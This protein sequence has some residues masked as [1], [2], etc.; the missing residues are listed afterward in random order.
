VNDDLTPP[1]VP[2]MDEETRARVRARLAEATTTPDTQ[3]GWR[4]WVLPIAA[5]AAVLVVALGVG[6]VAWWPGDDAAAPAGETTAP[7][8]PTAATAEPTSPSTA[9]STQEASSEPSPTGEESRTAPAYPNPTG[10]SPCGKAVDQQLQGAIEQVATW[11]LP[12]GVAGIWAAGGQAVLCED[13]GGIATA[14]RAQST[15]AAPVDAEQLIWSTS[16]YPVEGGLQTA[17]VA[18][19]RLPEG[20]TGIEYAWPD[21]HV[22]RA[23]IVDEG[24]RRWWL[25]SYVPTDGALVERGTN[26]LQLDDVHVTVSLSGTQRTFDLPFAASMCAQVNHGC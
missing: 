26:F 15:E 11:Q 5:A 7:T 2:P 9:G 25:A 4:R 14:H 12:G 24:D 3:P 16:T 17:F 21:G 23:R 6:A 19:G 8:G 20:V 22:E 18:G 13:S 1:A 10:E